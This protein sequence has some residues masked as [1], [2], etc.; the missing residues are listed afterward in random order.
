MAE[1]VAGVADIMGS[2]REPAWPDLTVSKRR[3]REAGEL[4]RTWAQGGGLLVESDVEEAHAV[5][6]LW[7]ACHM[8]VR[9]TAAMGA[10]W[11]TTRLEIDTEIGSRT[12]ARASILAKLLDRTDL[13]L[14]SIG[15]IAGA[16]AVVETLSDQERLVG[17]YDDHEQGRHRDY[18]G[19]KASGYRAVHLDLVLYDPHTLHEA[20]RRRR[21]ELQIRTRAQHD[22]ADTVEEVARR[23]GDRLKQ[24]AGAPWLLDALEELGVAYADLDDAREA[25]REQTDAASTIDRLVAA[26]DQRIEE[27]R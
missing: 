5:L 12:K 26:I 14:D 2:E 17:A 24:G 1:H 16:R 25:G 3:V 15:D 18:R 7:R 21:I 19:G 11:R 10:R 23:T 20:Q 8:F 4:L 13:K 22:W 27:E 6:S 9:N